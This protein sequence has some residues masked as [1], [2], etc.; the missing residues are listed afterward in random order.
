VEA[1]E[2]EGYGMKRR[3]RMARKRL[4]IAREREA[5]ADRKDHTANNEYLD[6]SPEAP[7]ENVWE[8]LRLLKQARRKWIRKAYARRDIERR[9]DELT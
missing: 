7:E 5:K 6:L 8:A 4:M 2:S 1:Q 3:I 9:K